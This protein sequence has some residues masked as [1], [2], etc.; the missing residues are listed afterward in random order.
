MA[1]NIFRTALLIFFISYVYSDSI[2]SIVIFEEKSLAE[3]RTNIELSN[4]FG[5]MI[6]SME[7]FSLSWE[8]IEKGYFYNLYLNLKNIKVNIQ[9]SMIEIS[10]INYDLIPDIEVLTGKNSID[11]NFNFD[12]EAKTGIFTTL[13]GKG[14]IKV[15]YF[16]Y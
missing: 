10:D 7:P 4:I 2:P 11:V 1:L 13:S 3:V 6:S 8:Y 15:K 5:Q 9:T 14:N 12:Y 16:I